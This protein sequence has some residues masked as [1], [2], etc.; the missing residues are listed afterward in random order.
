MEQKRI[1]RIN[2]LAK[3]AKTVG[4]T[5]EEIAERDRL[6]KEYVEAVRKNLRGQ[7]DNTYVVDE[8]GNKRKLTDLQKPGKTH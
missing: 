7:L 4:L 1:D 2:E 8:Q 3:K 6:R 5:E